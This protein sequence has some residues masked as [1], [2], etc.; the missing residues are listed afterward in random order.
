M[1]TL[2]VEIVTIILSHVPEY[3]IVMMFVCGLW[4]NI[5]RRL[6][7]RSSAVCLYEIVSMKR[8]HALMI[9][10]TCLCHQRCR[11]I[12]GFAHLCYAGAISRNRLF[13]AL[14]TIEN[15]PMRISAMQY[16]GV[17]LL[18]MI[19]FH[20][21][22]EMLQALYDVVCYEKTLD[23]NCY[24]FSTAEISWLL[25]QGFTVTDGLFHEIIGHGNDACAAMIA[26]AGYM[27]TQDSIAQYLHTYPTE[28]LEIIFSKGVRITKKHW[29]R[30]WDS[31]YLEL[32]A[33]L[34]I[35]KY[36]KNFK[37]PT[38]SKTPE[39][40][41]MPEDTTSILDLNNFNYWYKS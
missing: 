38:G 5:V 41:I 22:W 24:D 20:K 18:R 3:G 37:M 15:I 7:T 6:G 40:G 28:V 14:R 11:K 32:D 1:D 29:K 2:P 4:A 35:L 23:E 25:S 16:L 19:T 27:P 12:V 17:R 21:D 36:H 39:F 33:K 26:R 9:W 10:L 31:K 34:V 13:F 30:I 8:Q